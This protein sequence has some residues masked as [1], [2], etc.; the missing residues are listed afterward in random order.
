MKPTPLW[1]TTASELEIFGERLRDARVI[2]RLKAQAVAERADMTP[3]RYSRLENSLS[4]TVDMD[5]AHRL[6]RALEFPVKFLAAPPVTPVQRGSLLFRAKKAM[7]KG[8]EDQLVAW[9]RLVGDLIQSSVY[10]SVRLPYLKLPRTPNGTNPI[11]AAQLT[12]KALGIGNEE[13]IPHLTRSLERGGIYIAVLDFAAELHAKHH[14][15][16]STW[17]GPTFEWALIA[18]R[19]TSSWERTRLSIAHELGHLVMHYIRRDGD[20]EA[21]AYAFAAELLLPRSVLFD[22]WP[23]PATLMS[24]MPLKRTWGVSLAGLIEHGYR[25]GLLAEG[26]RTNLYKQLSNKKDRLS[27]ERWRVKEPGWGDREPERPKLIAKVAETA[28]GTS[29]DPQAISA[30]VCNWREDF[31][32]QLLEQQVTPWAARLAEQKK[33]LA[34]VL[35]FPKQV[36]NTALS[37]TTTGRSSG[38][39]STGRGRLGTA[40]TIE[41]RCTRKPA[42]SVT[43][44]RMGPCIP[45]AGVPVVWRRL[46]V[47]QQPDDGA[48][49][50]RGP[51][52]SPAPRAAEKAMV[53]IKR[54][55]V[56]GGDGS[57]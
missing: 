14:D 5:R 38:I 54:R 19:A 15:A 48:D 37:G 12:R 25:N 2:Q 4:T 1:G 47:A 52:A 18:V 45:Q 31:V 28:F 26:Q 8:E 9:A 35:A 29:A 16:F 33:P 7:T 11:D 21:E 36:D 44:C 24:L 3:D 13:P 10:E 20:L 43:A 27:G 50:G 39:R 42:S 17:L 56:G 53:R 57:W 34:L 51:A 30:R 55:S 49:H 40:Y 22:C 46:S 41:C 6:A 32:C 23:Q